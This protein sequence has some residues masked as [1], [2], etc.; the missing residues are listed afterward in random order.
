MSFHPR[1]A[2]LLTRGR[3]IMAASWVTLAGGCGPGAATP[4]PEPP[5]LVNLADVG[6]PEVLVAEAAANLHTIEG[7]AG[8]V[9]PNATVRVTNLDGTDPAYATTADGHGHFVI[10][11]QAVFGNELRFEWALPDKHSTAP[12]DAL[13]ESAAMQATSFTLVPS[14]RFDCVHL[15]PGYTLDF[16]ASAG[17]SLSVIV[18]NA[19]AGDVSLGAPR[20]RRALPEFSSAGAAQIISQGSSAS[21]AVGYSRTTPAASEDTLLFDITSSGTVIRYPVTLSAATKP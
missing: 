3:V 12:A 11:V 13:L 19:C 5:S 6:P 14:P 18:Q 7:R 17:S 9:P 10:T 21:L 20:L 2:P 8:A 1:I 15:T 4:M 16:G